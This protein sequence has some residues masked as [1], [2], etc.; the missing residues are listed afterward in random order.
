M[1]YSIALFDTAYWSQVQILSMRAYSSLAA[2]IYK[3][4]LKLSSQSRNDNATGK[5]LNLIVVDADKVKEAMTFI[6]F[7]WAS[8]IHVGLTMYFIWQ[9]IGPS[10]LVGTIF[11]R[12]NLLSPY[13]LSEPGLKR[14]CVYVLYSHPPSLITLLYSDCSHYLRKK[15]PIQKNIFKRLKFS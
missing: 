5:I 9:I 14:K 4:S 10:V 15:F 1:L 3:K 11:H 12:I 8:P 7:L 13:H 2:I 6:I